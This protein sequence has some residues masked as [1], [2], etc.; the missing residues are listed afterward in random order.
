MADD[1]EGEAGPHACRPSCTAATSCTCMT[2]MPIMITTTIFDDD[3][4]PLE[5]NPLW[6]ARQRDAHERR[7]RHR[8]FRHASDLFARSFASPGARI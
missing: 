5:D 4:G 8:L 6:L 3:D 7:H 1:E 2:A